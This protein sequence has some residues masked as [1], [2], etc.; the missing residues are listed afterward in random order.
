MI[1]AIVT[2]ENTLADPISVSKLMDST[3]NVPGSPDRSTL[4]YN[5][6]IP[7]PHLIPMTISI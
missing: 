4:R 2:N 6:G 1:I 3:G 7:A 5:I